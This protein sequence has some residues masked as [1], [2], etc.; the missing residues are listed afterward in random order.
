MDVVVYYA[1]IAKTAQMLY[2]AMIVNLKM[3]SLII[4]KEKDIKAS[5]HNK[6]V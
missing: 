4:A 1:P 6:L 2:F 5:F 3:T